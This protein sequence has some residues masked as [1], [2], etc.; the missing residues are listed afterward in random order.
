MTLGY[1]EADAAGNIGSE[2]GFDQGESKRHR[3]IYIIDRSIPVGYQPGQDL[4][5]ENVILLRRVIE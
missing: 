1:F 5:T 3:A 4:N 2:Y